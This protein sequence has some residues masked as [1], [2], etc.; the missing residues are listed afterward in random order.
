[1][2]FFTDCLRQWNGW[3]GWIGSME[4]HGNFQKIGEGVET[5]FTE[6]D[7]QLEIPVSQTVIASHRPHPGLLWA[8]TLGPPW[9]PL[10]L[11]DPD[12]QSSAS[13]LLM[14]ASFQDEPALGVLPCPPWNI[15]CF[16]IAAQACAMSLGGGLWKPTP[17]GI[18]S[19]NNTPYTWM[20]P[21]VSFKSQVS[22]PSW[23]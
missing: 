17:L 22:L 12:L 20:G 5:I 3:D 15:P 23:L 4:Y 18:L 1:M 14:D 11:P 13:A 7:E 2:F 21:N 6:K 16:Q 10:W 8:D 19:L 9:R